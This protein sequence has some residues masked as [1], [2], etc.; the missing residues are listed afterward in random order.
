MADICDDSDAI[1]EAFIERG[2]KAAQASLSVRRL[3]PTG[4]CHNSRCEADVEEGKLFCDN[5]C[6]EEHRRTEKL[7]AISGTR[8]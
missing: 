8:H 4:I 5:Q 1:N 7:R 6:A 3:A 2:V